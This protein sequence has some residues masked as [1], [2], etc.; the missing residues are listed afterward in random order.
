MTQPAHERLVRH[1]TEGGLKTSQGC[2]ADG[3]REF[4]V[5]NSL[6]LPEDLRAYFLRVNG[7]L[8]EALE[9]SDLNGFCF[10][11]LDRVKSVTEE[12]VRHSL[13][14]R[15]SSED[16]QYFVFADYMQWSW[17]YSIRLTDS[18]DGPNPVIHVGTLE[19]KVVANSFTH[20]VDS[21]LRDA[22]ELYPVRLPS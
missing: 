12:I 8:P 18:A 19:P 13:R 11:P 22:E 9:D 16:H 1:W 6:V 20:F 14:I 17:A 4:E 2:P 3:A 5:K 10:W 15:Q 21:Y 7:M